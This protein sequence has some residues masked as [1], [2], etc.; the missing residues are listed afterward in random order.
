[1]YYRDLAQMEKKNGLS[2]EISVCLLEMERMASSSQINYLNGKQMFY[3]YII[4]ANINL[5]NLLDTNI[6]L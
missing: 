3:I 1:M 6:A 5:S 2:S 4:I